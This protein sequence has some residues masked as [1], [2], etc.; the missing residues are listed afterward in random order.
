MH[1]IRIKGDPVEI[2]DPKSGPTGVGIFCVFLFSS[3]VSN[4]KFYSELV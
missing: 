3:V 2:R 1:S 4:S